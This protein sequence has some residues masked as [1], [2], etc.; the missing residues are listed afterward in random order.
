MTHHSC[1]VE[2][3]GTRAPGNALTC[4]R[5]VEAASR[6]RK[7]ARR[8][9][10]GAP[11]A[12]VIARN[13]RGNVCFY[14]DF[15]GRQHFSF[16][17]RVWLYPSVPMGVTPGMSIKLEML[18]INLLTPVTGRRDYRAAVGVTSK[19]VRRLARRLRAP[20]LLTEQSQAWVRRRSTP[21]R[22]VHSPNLLTRVASAERLGLLRIQIPSLKREAM[23]PPNRRRSA[24][25]QA[26][27][28]NEGGHGQALRRPRR[29]LPVTAAAKIRSSLPSGAAEIA[30]IP[31]PLDRARA[32]TDP[33]S[34]SS[35]A[36]PFRT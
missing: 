30:H 32:R 29:S 33:R 34:L 14:V 17:Q 16:P 20:C 8:L 23:M 18:A 28:D 2:R 36:A 10:P 24:N 21:R 27:A 26:A 1:V 9:L 4:G 35:H 3:I 25:F 7:C 31:P 22:L 12:S 13:A 6:G 5:I 15:Q 11:R 19:R